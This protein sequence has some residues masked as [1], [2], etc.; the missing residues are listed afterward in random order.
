M[1][2]ASTTP[3]T[4]HFSIMYQD[5]SFMTAGYY[6]PVE[7]QDVEKSVQGAA[8][9]V[10]ADDWPE[11]ETLTFDVE[12]DDDQRAMFTVSRDGTDFSVTKH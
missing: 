8:G 12:W 3:S 9:Q 10:H 11:G 2:S 7:A 5:G 6:C 4:L 1:S